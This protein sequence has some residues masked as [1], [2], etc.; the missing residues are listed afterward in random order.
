M[1]WAEP[2][3]ILRRKQPELERPYKVWGYPFVPLLFVLMAGLIVL[4]TILNDFKNSF[5]GLVVVL[6]GLPAYFYWNRQKGQVPQQ[7]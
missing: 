1:R 2:V 3:F 6:S 7:E 4:N 5:W